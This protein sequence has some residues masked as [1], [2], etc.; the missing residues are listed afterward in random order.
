MSHDVALQ[1]RLLR[2][3]PK[4]F[5]R[6]GVKRM[7]SA[8]LVEQLAPSERTMHGEEITRRCLSSLL[9]K[10]GI[11]TRT[12]RVNGKVCRGYSLDDF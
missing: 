12:V 7:A 3:I 10:L 11:R 5:R 6:L 4:V 9:T 1:R 2:D 8:D